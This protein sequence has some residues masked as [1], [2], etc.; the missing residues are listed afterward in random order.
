M[1][2]DDPKS[3][4]P[5]R[6]RRSHQDTKE[7]RQHRQPQE[8][9]RF[10]N[11]ISIARP[12]QEASYLEWHDELVGGWATPL[13]NISQLGW[14][15]TQYMGKNV[16][17]HQPVIVLKYLKC[18][19]SPNHPVVNRMTTTFFYWKNRGD[20]GPNKRVYAPLISEEIG[21]S[22]SLQQPIWKSHPGFTL[23]KESSG[24]ISHN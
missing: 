17:N 11:E 9:I 10:C 13:K 3:R 7:G 14:L 5:D 19:C 15:E 4:K 20:W 18:W 21:C 16:P 22:W 24:I 1:T 12:C 6:P 8:F 2:H 23:S